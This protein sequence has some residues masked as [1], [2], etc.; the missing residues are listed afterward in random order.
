[1]AGLVVRRQAARTLGHDAALLLRA[2]D[3]LQDRLVDIRLHD[4]AALAARGHDGGL[5]EEV[6]QIRTGKAG[7][8][9]RNALE[10]HIVAQR[11]AAGVDLQDL[12]A[13]LD[14]GQP[15]IH[16][17]VKAAGA[18]QR[19]IENVGAVGRRHD[20]DALVIRKAVHLDEQLVERLLALVVTAA[21]TAA[22]L[23]A[24]R[25][26]LVDEHDGR[27][28]LLGLVEQIA[29]TRCTDTDIELD[30]VRARNGQKLHA[31]LARDCAG[32]ERLAGARRADEQHALGDARAHRGIVLRALE[33]VHDLG[34]LLFFLFRAGDIGKRNLLEVLLAGARVRLAELADA[35]RSAAARLVHEQVPHA[36][37]QHDRDQVRQDGHPPRRRP[38]LDV[39]ILRQHAAGGLL[40][41]QIPQILTEP[42]GA[43]KCLFDC[44]VAVAVRRIEIERELISLEAERLDLLLAEQFLDLGIGVFLLLCRCGQ[45]EDDGENDHADQ[46]VEP[47]A[48]GT[49][50]IRFQIKSRPLWDPHRGAQLE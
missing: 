21:E 45:I 4:E 49:V 39:I 10:I 44:R 50:L 7:R 46:Q 43:R 16:A 35:R 3:D 40:L 12:L 8:A 47:D 14:I 29:H 18:Q 20:D 5:V 30:K 9:A 32:H 38:A 36:D 28:D 11:L 17:P 2:H 24:D 41:D 25:V 48:S 1:M 37:E 26:D 33:E 42:G 19:V 34:Q 15:H 27:G 13:A 31:C 6:L 22:A 23:A